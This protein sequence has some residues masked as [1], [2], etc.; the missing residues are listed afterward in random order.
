MSSTGTEARK[1]FEFEKA[2]K[3]VTRFLTMKK[4]LPMVFDQM[5]SLCIEICF[6][7]VSFDI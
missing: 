1:S 7:F 6:S 3:F 4:N 5:I 2:L